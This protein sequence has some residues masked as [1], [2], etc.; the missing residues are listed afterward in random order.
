MAGQPGIQTMK[1]IF[2]LGLGTLA[3][4]VGG[5]W[6][7]RLQRPGAANPPAPNALAPSLGSHSAKK[8]VSVTATSSPSVTVS[9]NNRP[10]GPQQKAVISLKE[11]VDTGKQARV[12]SV[13]EDLNK[14]YGYAGA[15]SWDEAKALIARREQ[16]TKAL[17]DQ[18]T[19]LGPGGARAIGATYTETGDMRGKL[20]LIDALGKIQDGEA[21][22]ILQLLFSSEGSFN[23]QRE[24]VVALGQRQD[25]AAVEALGEIAA[26]QT[27]ARLRFATAQALNG[28]AD[29]LPV[30]AQLI[31]T[32]TDP[33]VQKELILSAGAIGN[34]AALRVVAGI[35]QSATDIDVR[36]TAIQAL[37]RNF[38][39]GALNALK[40]L[41]NDPDQVIRGNVLTALGGLHS[42]DA[43][44]LL[45]QTAASDS[46]AQVREQ[47]QAILSAVSVR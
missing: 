19:A 44:S 39:A 1:K 3:L 9:G 17:L 41:L 38:G 32:E 25:A 12:A 40:Q 5:W 24:M 34:D 46:S 28:R 37:S 31:Q 16:A 35:A 11:G 22:A 45:R 33:N 30:L 10:R 21:G 15:L 36:Q 18:L 14:Q 13:L 27:D 29:A 7:M 2:I 4:V 47:A 20:L 43:L 26:S 6:L 23:L 42:D 8:S